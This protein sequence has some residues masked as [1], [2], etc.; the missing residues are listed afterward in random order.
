VSCRINL[1]LNCIGGHS[2]R[3]LASS[4][5]MLS[6]YSHNCN[7]SSNCKL[8]VRQHEFR[9]RNIN[10]LHKLMGHQENIFS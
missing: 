2:R 9:L 7:S 10:R 4:I 6:S 3:V 5:N 8:L 1:F